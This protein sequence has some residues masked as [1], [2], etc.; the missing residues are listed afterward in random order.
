MLPVAPPDWKQYSPDPP[1]DGRS[2]PEIEAYQPLQPPKP[3]RSLAE[4]TVR[5]HGA[6]SRVT[7][8]ALLAVGAAVAGVV[9]WIVVDLV[10]MALDDGEPQTVE[11]FAEMVEELDD[12]TG[13]TEV[14]EA[15]LY[16]DYAVLDVPVGDDERYVG[17][18]WDGRFSDGFKGTSDYVTFDLADID[19]T[20]FED[21]C[22]EVSARIDDPETC[23]LI[24]RRPDPDD[25]DQ[26]WISAH[27]SNEFSQSAWIDYDLEGKE[28]SRSED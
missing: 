8:V 17:H 28:V 15:V 25:T 12:E 10:R 16:P 13:G 19:P 21:M 26:S 4:R 27:V 18:R 1:P 3:V 23:Y 22:A 11:G 14:F 5:D 24:V 6:G 20:P 2:G 9:G 7:R